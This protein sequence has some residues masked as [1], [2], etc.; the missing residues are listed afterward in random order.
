MTSIEIP[1]WSGA[2]LIPGL[3]AFPHG[4]LPLHIFEP[5][6]RKM[7]IDAMAADQMICVGNLYS[8]E[9]ADLSKCVRKVGTI[10]LLH[11]VEKRDNGCSD[12]ILHSVSRVEFLSWDL[13]SEYPRANI[14]P[15][16]SIVAPIS[17]STELL[18]ESLR[19]AV[20]R[21]LVQLPEDVAPEIDHALDRVN[22]DLAVL[23]DV[24]AQQFV[25]DSK[26]RQNLLAEL[27]ANLRA[28]ILIRHLRLQKV[29][30]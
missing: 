24:V 28:E 3:T 19:D 8:D 15:I 9:V 11:A 13:T 30:I 16:T 10:G 21:I 25:S 6:Y 26:V 29:T 27:D 14:S 2:I 22:E 4:M 20:T 18:I 17:D 7:L 12:L 23:T 5:R 1:E